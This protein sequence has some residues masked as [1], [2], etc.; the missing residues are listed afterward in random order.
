[1]RSASDASRLSSMAKGRGSEG[2][3]ISM[4]RATTSISPVLMEAFTMS[5]GRASTVPVTDSTNSLRILCAALV[6]SWLISGLKTT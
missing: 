5:P 3:R 6:S 2:F 4:S 1:M